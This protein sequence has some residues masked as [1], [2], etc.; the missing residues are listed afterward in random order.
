MAQNTNLEQ[1]TDKFKAGS[2]CAQIMAVYFAKKFGE[3]EG[4]AHQF[5]CSFGGGMRQGDV[6]GAVTGGLF[7]LSMK[8]G[9]ASPE[10]ADRKANCYDD[11]IAFGKAFRERYGSMQCR[12]LLAAAASSDEYKGQNIHQTFCPKVVLAAIELLEEMGC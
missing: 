7:A 5:M 6:C 1:I 8:A 4:K 10:E 12:D 9:N 3:D 11:T 2:N